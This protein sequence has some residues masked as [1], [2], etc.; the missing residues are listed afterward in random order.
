M[1]CDNLE[2]IVKHEVMLF[3]PD[4][5]ITI[6]DLKAVNPLFK[7]IPAPTLIKAL[8]AIADKHPNYTPANSHERTY[9]RR[10]E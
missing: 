3:R 10:K 1:I 6:E 7:E 8:K 5:P 9:W 2:E 4:A